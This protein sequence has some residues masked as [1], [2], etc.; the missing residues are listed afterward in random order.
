MTRRAEKSVGY[1]LYLIGPVIECDNGESY[2]VAAFSDSKGFTIDSMVVPAGQDPV[3]A[4]ASFLRAAQNNAFSE[5][6]AEAFDDEHALLIR[7][8]AIW[9]SRKT[10][11]ALA[12]FEK[13]MALAERLNEAGV[14]PD[15]VLH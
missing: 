7:A 15:D 3:E 6:G 11:H 12:E 1:G 14:R 5:G 2:F 9:P 4:R 10:K 13:S 8:A